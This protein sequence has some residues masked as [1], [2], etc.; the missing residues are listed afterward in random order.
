M[1]NIIYQVL[2]RL[3]GDG[4]FASWDQ[5]SF[6]YLKTLG[7]NCIWFTGIPRHASGEAFVKGDPGCPYAVCDWYDVNP[8][9][10]SDPSRRIEEFRSLVQRTHEAGLRCIVDFIP[11]HVAC[12]YRGGLALYDWHD[13]DWSHRPHGYRHPGFAVKNARVLNPSISKKEENIIL[14]QAKLLAK[15]FEGTDKFKPYLAKW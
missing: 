15:A 14:R 3:W 9:L 12:N 11:N 2:P 4:T 10:A 13:G 5:R 1:K 8:Y 6:D 7:V